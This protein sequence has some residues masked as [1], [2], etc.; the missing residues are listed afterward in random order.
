MRDGVRGPL[1]QKYQRTLVAFRANEP[2]FRVVPPT[3]TT[4]LQWYCL[5]AYHTLAWSYVSTYHRLIKLE[6]H[7]KQN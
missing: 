3:T 1:L 5:G 6:K 2:T 7:S 4:I